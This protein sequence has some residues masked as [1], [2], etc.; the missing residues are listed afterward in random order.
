MVD[1][2]NVDTYRDRTRQW[3]LEA[4]KWPLGHQ[5]D[6]CVALAEGYENLVRLIENSGTLT[7]V[8]PAQETGGVQRIAN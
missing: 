4:E 6:A 8:P 3:R 1:G 2:W 7:P 5:H